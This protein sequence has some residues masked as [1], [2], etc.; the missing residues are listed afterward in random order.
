MNKYYNAYNNLTP[1]DDQDFVGVKRQVGIDF[2]KDHP[3]KATKIKKMLVS[4]IIDK[5]HIPK[6]NLKYVH[7]L[8]FYESESVLRDLLV[9]GEHE[10]LIDKVLSKLEG[11]F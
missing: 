4:D 2:A 7:Q 8:F 11:T 3:G 5:Y 1:L 10:Y 9:F 6:D